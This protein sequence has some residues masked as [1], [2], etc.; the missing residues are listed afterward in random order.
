MNRF[1]TICAIVGATACIA[2]QAASA[3]SSVCHEDRP[4][5][6]W[7]TMGN[8]QRGLWTISGKHVVV[9]ARQFDILNRG[10]RINWDTSAGLKGDG[11][12][13]DAQDY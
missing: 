7:R 1:T 3:A 13:F 12:R 9:T 6:N 2:P 10:F 5:F 11:H 4:C 8:H